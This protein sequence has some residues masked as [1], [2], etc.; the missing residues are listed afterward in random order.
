MKLWAGRWNHGKKYIQH[1]T[2]QNLLF[3]KDVS[4]PYRVNVISTWLQYQK[5]CKLI[6]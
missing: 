6:N 1:I 2:K 4:K 3:L 5:M